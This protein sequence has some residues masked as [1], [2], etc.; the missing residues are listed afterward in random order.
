[1]QQ[2]YVPS[3]PSLP[4]DEFVHR[5]I[6]RDNI[7]VKRPVAFPN[8]GYDESAQRLE[9]CDRKSEGVRAKSSCLL[10]GVVSSSLVGRSG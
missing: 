1:M 8:I 3:R 7:P 9:S 5:T 10:F 2:V 6:V 4:S